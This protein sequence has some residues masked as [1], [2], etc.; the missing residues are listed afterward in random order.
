MD[1]RD[2]ERITYPRLLKR[3]LGGYYRF[4]YLEY[5]L[6]NSK[7]ERP[8]IMS[9]WG[10][11]DKDFT[12]TTIKN[13][14]AVK[15]Q[16]QSIYLMKNNHIYIK[17]WRE[18][19]LDYLRKKGLQRCKTFYNQKLKDDW[20]VEENSGDM[21]LFDDIY[22]FTSIVHN[23]RIVAVLNTLNMRECNAFVGSLGIDPETCEFKKVKELKNLKSKNSTKAQSVGNIWI[24]V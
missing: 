12:P 14:G 24:K 1:F 6:P 19:R 17:H 15:K 21:S 20:F 18:L 8:I 9:N 5:L 2:R 7:D 23:K 11:L 13:R 10:E 22:K 16:Y 3:V 4:W